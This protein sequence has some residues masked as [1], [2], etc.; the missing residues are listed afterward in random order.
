MT[1]NKGDGASS[2]VRLRR[3]PVDTQRE[4]LAVMG[5]VPLFEGLSQKDL[6]TIRTIA[7]EVHHAKGAEIVTQ[8]REGVG[9]H[10]I[11]EGE[12]RAV[13]GRRTVSRFGPGSYFGELSLVDG[14]PRSATVIAETDVRTLS[15][16]R[17]SFMPL[18]D[19]HPTITKK[20]LIEACKRLRE[21]NARA[22]R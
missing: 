19:K 11:I 10:L 15:I 2:R 1:R 3:K 7:K 8:G 18:L 22:S 13:V 9:F 17:W 12:A 14:G 4:Q 20:M 5:S 16:P 21:T 6:R